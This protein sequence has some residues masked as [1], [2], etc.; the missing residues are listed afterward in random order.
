MFSKNNIS[1]LL[2]PMAT[3]LAV[4]VLSAVFPLSAQRTNKDVVLENTPVTYNMLDRFEERFAVMDSLIFRNNP[5][6]RYTTSIDTAFHAFSDTARI[7]AIDRATAAR[8]GAMKSKTGLDFRGQVY[9]RPGKQLS[10][11]PDDPLVAYNAKAQAEL[12]WNIFQSAAYKR[13]GKTREIM[14]KGELEQLNY[15]NNDLQEQLL[16]LKQQ[17]RTIYY[18]QLLSVITTHAENVRLL[19][20]TQLYLLEHGKISGDDLLKLINEQSELERQ[21]ISIKA[22]S[23]IDP[24][25]PA[26]SAAYITVADTAGIFRNIQSHNVDLRRLGLRHEILGQQRKNLD[27]LQTMAIQPF[28]RFSYYN[29]EHVHNTYNLDVGVSFTLPISREV[30]KKKQE[31]RAEQDVVLYEQDCISS[32]TEKAIF[33][34]FHDLEI[35]N[36][37]ILG[38]HLRM[39]NLKKFLDM[40]THSY[41]NVDGE[42]SRIARLQEYNAYLQSWERLLD[43]VY[44]RDCI[45]LDLQRYL[46]TEPVT[47]YIQFQE[48]N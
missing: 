23:V 21:L 15:V 5:D 36:E 7:E 46:L 27:Y 39:N 24:L 48:L 1:Q 9:V 18:G 38:E 44:R 2:A 12:Q 16:V 31:L 30:S 28:A 37:N 8:I 26:T 13:K 45:L 20:E 40:R 43:F 41:S 22:D 14:L 32:E 35:Y 42:Y 10:Y 17:L 19:M 34:S 29:R 11:D 4:V 47:N 33:L 6:I 25:E 3:A